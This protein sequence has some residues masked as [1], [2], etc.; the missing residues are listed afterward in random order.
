[1][2]QERVAENVY[3]FTSDLYAQ[4]NAG[5]V[6]GP[7]W[8]I[9]IDTLAFPEETLE[10]K[11]FLE[12]RLNAPV[13]YVINTHYH[14]DHTLGTCWFPSATVVSH[15]RCRDLLD[16]VGRQAL[17]NAKK[18]NRDL[19]DVEIVLPDLVFDR[20]E[21]LLKVGKRTLR[22]IHLPGHSMD[23]VGV[24]VVEDKVL[25]S[26]DIMM[27]IPYI[28]DG[29]FNVMIDSMKRIP[30]L[31]LENL[32]Q[33]HGDVILRGEVG[34]S[35]KDNLNYLSTIRRH[36]KKAKSRSDPEE[37]LRSIDVESCGK[38]RI[39]LNGLVE[40]LHQRNMQTLYERSNGEGEDNA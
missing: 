16:T 27:P 1:M 35:V 5:A 24:L 8:S 34:S 33:G 26:G 2:V 3:L 30:G 17:A 23:N 11:D 38:A 36:V 29:D 14:S 31:K 39:L 25:F 28:V 4:V 10:I 9:L 40:Q 37:Y 15:S 32:I 6:V 20:G 13:R 12:N 21:L 18:Q 22:L 19:K 7:E